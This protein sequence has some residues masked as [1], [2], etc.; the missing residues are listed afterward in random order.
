MMQKRYLLGLMGLGSLLILLSYRPADTKARGPVEKAT[1]GGG[2][3]WCMEPPFEKIEGVYTVVSGYSGGPEKNPT[4][5]EVSRG[6][7]GHTEVV[8]IEFD[9]NRVS[10]AH[11]VEV[12][13]RSMNPTDLT[14][15][16]ADRGSQYRPAIFFHS[17]A[18]KQVAERSKQKL[19]NSGVF[20]KP[21]A[22][23]IVPFETFYS[24]EEYHQDYYK[25]NPRHYKRYSQ[26]SG[27]DGFLK[28]TWKDVA[29]LQVPRARYQKP[30]DETL[31]STLSPLQ[32]KVTQQDG[33]EPPFKNAFWDH[34]EEGIYVDITSGEPLFS[35]KHKF[36]SGTGWPSFTQPLVPAHVVEKTDRSY[37]M[38]RIEVRSKYGDAHLG[39]LFNDGPRP[40]GL[41]YCI[42]SAALRFVPKAD[43][44]DKGY[45]EWASHFD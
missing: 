41:R 30:S 29:P 1:F 27:R 2:C 42:N 11:L 32:Y 40:T 26:G 22:V 34:K 6:K 9:P 19:Q 33:T 23:P 15:Q 43:L 38:V 35:S 25:K 37:G 36:K 8:Q 3:F 24:A 10:F 45:A 44:R 12:F 39:H 7:T 21:I 16:F 13:W 28:A 4:Y 5:E 20:K 31:K 14:G 17:P 18:Q